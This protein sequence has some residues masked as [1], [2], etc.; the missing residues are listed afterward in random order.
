MLRLM[1]LERVQTRF[2]EASEIGGW[3][4]HWSRVLSGPLIDFCF[5]RTC[6]LCHGP[7]DLRR[8]WDTR[9]SKRQRGLITFAMKRWGID[10]ADVDALRSGA[11]ATIRGPEDFFCPI[12]LGGLA[13][14]APGLTCHR[15]GHPVADTDAAV[16][17]DQR[18][19]KECILGPDEESPFDR[20]I[21]LGKYSD[22]LREAVIVAKQSQAS[23]LA[24]GL[25]NLLAWRL[26]CVLDVDSFPDVVTCVPS[27]WTRRFHRRSWPTQ[28]L[29]TEV[30]ANL[31]VPLRTMVQMVRRTKKQGMLSD[32]ERRDNVQGAFALKRKL[33]GDER[34][35]LIIDD[36]WTTGSTMRAV[37]SVLKHAIPEIKVYGGVVARAIGAHN[38]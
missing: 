38:R 13:G 24:I 25:G 18:V 37:A 34:S 33:R 11:P 2:G 9:S 31:G 26:R 35:V 3:L 15:C 4:S 20:V 8:S 21:V 10:I 29:A 7:N 14:S 36:V 12:C 5:P 22:V 16:P 32:I 30:G 19:C 27:H 28:W 1:R 23:P 6:V 17:P